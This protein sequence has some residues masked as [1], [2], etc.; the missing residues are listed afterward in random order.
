YLADRA[1]SSCAGVM[2]IYRW[3]HDRMGIPPFFEDG[4]EIGYYPIRF[5]NRRLVTISQRKK[6]LGIYGNHNRGIRPKFVGFSVRSSMWVM[7]FHGLARWAK[8]EIANAWTYVVK[9]KPIAKPEPAPAAA[10]EPRGAAARYVPTALVTG[11]SS[12]IGLEVSKLLARDRHD[13]V[14]IGRDRGRLDELGASVST[15]FGVATTVLVHDLAD[16]TAPPAIA[17]EISKRAFAIDVLVNCAG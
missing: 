10:A 2:P 3:S 7:L 8:V 5:Y 15:Q 1:L 17:R 13:L 9:P 14:L 12:G 16:P 11:A 4:A 6:A